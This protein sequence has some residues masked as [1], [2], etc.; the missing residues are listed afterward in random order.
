MCRA[1]AP[2]QANNADVPS[3]TPVASMASMASMV[4]VVSAAPVPAV[5]PAPPS[6]GMVL[7]DLREMWPGESFVGVSPR[8]STR[9]AG[10]PIMMSL[11]EAIGRTLGR[12]DSLAAVVARHESAGHLANAAR[13]GFL[14]SVELR[15]ADGRERS[16]PSS[17]ID[18]TTGKVVPTDTHRRTEY[19]GTLVVPIYKPAALS[20]WRRTQAVRD[21]VDGQRAGARG[22]TVYAAVKAYYELLRAGMLVQVAEQSHARLEKLHRQASVR[23]EAG[24]SSVAEHDRI[25]ARMLAAD[26]V[27]ADAVAQ[28][29]LASAAFRELTGATAT[30]LEI[31]DAG[32]AGALPALEHAIDEASRTNPDVLTARANLRATAE[33]RDAARARFLPQVTFELS[34][35]RVKNAGGNPGWQDD[36]RAM[37]VLAVPLFS[38]GGD[39]NRQRAALARERQLDHEV[40]SAQRQVEQNL[41]TVYTALGAAATKLD[42]L[43]RQ[44]QSARKVAVA[45][46]AQRVAASRSLLDVFDAYQQYQQAQTDRVRA[47]IEAVLLHYQ[48]S[49]LTGALDRAAGST[50]L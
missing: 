18:P 32:R 37:L 41:S 28:V 3:S 1:Q 46:E 39:L 4:S 14:P 45:F 8:T 5:S 10:P 25:R 50:G 29:D 35:V 15:G 36:R 22:E 48:V 2:D 43:R 44:E 20:E 7:A 27:R 33:E 21:S 34:Q 11:D 16:S 23:A 30:R 47:S 12:S 38:G 26:A 42:L 31:P 13:A 19:A 6:L 9:E 24:A 17:L 40:R 49:R